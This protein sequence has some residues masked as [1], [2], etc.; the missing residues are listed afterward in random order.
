MWHQERQKNDVMLDM[1]LKQMIPMRAFIWIFLQRFSQRKQAA[2]GK[3]NHNPSQE[4]II[5]LGKKMVRGKN[6]VTCLL[7][8]KNHR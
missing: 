3:G 2:Y 8:T 6:T 4:E 5:S 7:C 1:E